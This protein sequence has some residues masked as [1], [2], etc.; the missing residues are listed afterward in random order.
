MIV[1]LPFAFLAGFVTILSPCILPVLPV[2]LSGSV[3]GKSRPFGVITG[4]IAS[5]SVFT[6]ILS[7]LVQ[8]LNI[9][10][11]A[12]RIAAVVLI[13][14]F[15]LIMLIPQLRYGF[16]KIASR[17]ANVGGAKKQSKGFTGG[18][19]IGASL[20]LV[21]TPCVGPIMAS[22]IS[23]AITQSIDGGS[24]LII[25][26][27]SLGT[28]IPML[29]IML[30]GRTLLKRIPLLSRNLPGV[31]RI[32]GVLMILVGIAIGFGWDRSFQSVIL[33]I[34]PNYGSGLTVFENA[35]PVRRALDA[36]NSLS[37]DDAAIAGPTQIKFDTTPK[38]GI[39]GDFGPAPEFVTQGQWFNS[40]ELGLTGQ[41]DEITMSDLRGK[42]VLVDFWTYSCVNCVRTIPHL[43]AWYDTYKDDGFVI[44]GVHTPEFVFERKPENVQKAMGKLGVNWPVVLDNGYAQWRAYKNRY[45]PAHYFID[46]VGRVRYFHFGEGKYDIAEKVIRALLEEAGSVLTARS[47]LRPEAK[48]ESQ[49]AETYLGYSRAQGFSSDTAPVPNRPTLY[50]PAKKPANGEWT[51]E[52]NWTIAG[53]YVVPENSGVL[54]LGFYAKDVFLVIEPSEGSGQISVT[55]DGYSANNTN[56]VRD[57]LLV[58]DSSRLYHLVKQS[59]PGEHILRLEVDGDLRLFAF[60]FG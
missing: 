47:A 34:L 57:G 42:V 32:F 59:K 23:L 13:I 3:G 43:R 26:V 50:K 2:V 4:F 20:G 24:I 15:G 35:E 48:L 7:T 10:P 8:A 33:R 41:V 37:T 16:E 54:E 18:L 21:W 1:L 53:E 6:L 49:T 19:L 44:I 27:Y 45:W 11:D 9:P 17:I 12:L 29:A 51:L 22:V 52:G 40:E 5:F 25:L 46:A 58:T 39:L 30:G 31:Q 56:D 14:S 38:D 60:T 28:A 55:V 36:R